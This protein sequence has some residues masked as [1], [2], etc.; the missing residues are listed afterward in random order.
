VVNSSLGLRLSF[1]PL[2]SAD[3][4]PF[5]PPLLGFCG[6]D[7]VGH[8]AVKRLRLHL[9]RWAGPR[10]ADQPT[11]FNNTGEPRVKLPVSKLNAESLN[12]D[13]LGS[14]LKFVCF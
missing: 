6:G 10:S 13:S 3:S 1:Q 2:R 4:P 11:T 12:G 9:S 8:V 5:A 14:E 7:C